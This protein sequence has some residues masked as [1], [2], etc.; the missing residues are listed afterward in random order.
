MGSNKGNL[1]LALLIGIAFAVVLLP[2]FA[3]IVWHK[4]RHARARHRHH[5]HQRHRR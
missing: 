3:M 2:P 4:L 1:V 5:R